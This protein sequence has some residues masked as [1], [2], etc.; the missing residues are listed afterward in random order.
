MG[1]KLAEMIGPSGALVAPV[2]PDDPWSA[3]TARLQCRSELLPEDRIRMERM[4]YSYGTAAESYDIVISQGSLLTVPS[5]QG[6]LSVLPNGR[7]W[8]MPGGLLV[9]EELKP[10]C[11]NWL[12]QVS[13]EHNKTVAVYSVGDDDA[14]ILRKGNRDRAQF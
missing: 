8:H 2:V 9:P 14:P 1:L 12:K 10:H 5:G 11:V 4:A 6:M 13:H 7:Y 3:G